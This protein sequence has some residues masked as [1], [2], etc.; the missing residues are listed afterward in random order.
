MAA[1]TPTPEGHYV[2]RVTLPSG[3][4][5]DVVYFES[6]RVEAEQR[7]AGA[8]AQELHVCPECVFDLVYPIEWE[9]AGPENW[10]VSL[11]CPNCEWT[12][13]G[14]FSQDLVDEFDE[15]LDEGTEQLLSDLK[16][17]MHANMSEEIDRFVTALDAEALLPEDF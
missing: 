9:E 6:A 2:K 10:R 11:R 12:V 15:V 17:L 1:G 4:T 16:Q 13:T 3:K 14:V 7:G 8:P 5:I